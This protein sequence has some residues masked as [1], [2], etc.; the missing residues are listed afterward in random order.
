VG[1]YSLVNYEPR[2]VSPCFAVLGVC[3][4]CSILWADDFPNRRLFSGVAVIQLFMLLWTFAIPALTD[5]RHPWSSESGDRTPKGSYQAI[6]EGATKMG[7]HPGDQIASLNF[8]NLGTA[9]WAR[10]AR[11]QIIAE[12]YY[13][14]GGPEGMANCF[15]NA[16][17]A[18]QEKLLQRLSQTGAKAVVS[19]DVPTGSGAARWSRI[20]NT[21]YYLL[22]LNS[23]T[24]APAGTASDTSHSN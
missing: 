8:S 17:P 21:G 24:L 23:A 9:M 4:F 6:A 1:L 10:L 11:I 15:W 13:W 18:T 5:I 20:G 2:Y 19:S 16:D 14:P 22:W 7:L 12:I 3:L